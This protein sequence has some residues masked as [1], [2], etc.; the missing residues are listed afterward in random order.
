MNYEELDEI[1]AWL[2][3]QGF[4]IDLSDDFWMED[5]R[6]SEHKVR[7]VAELIIDYH[8]EKVKNL[9]LPRV[10]Q[11]REQLIAFANWWDISVPIF[12]VTDY[13][14]QVDKYLNAINCG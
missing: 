8:K 5:Y 7:D 10:S 11:Q 6:F 1:G 2:N 14:E 4:D 3:S 9:T 12:E 13:E